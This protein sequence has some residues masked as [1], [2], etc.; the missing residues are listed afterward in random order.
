[1]AISGNR[2]FALAVLAVGSSLAGDDWP[3]WRGPHRDGALASFIAP[4][5]W[6]ETLKRK[7]TVT[8]GEGHASPVFASGKLFVFTRQ[9]TEEALTCIAPDSGKILWRTAYPAPYKVNPAADSHGAGPKSTPVVYEGKV[10]TLGIGGVLSSF[11]AATGKPG[12]RKNFSGEFRETSPWYGTATSPVVDGGMVIA[13]VGGHDDGALMAFDAATGAVKW[14]WQ[15]DGP[16]Y[17]SPILVELAGKRQVIT[18]T[19]QNIVGVAAATGELLWKIPFTTEFTQNA[20]TPLRYDDM[21]IF[22]GL[23]NGTRAVRVSAKNGKWLTDTVWHNKE[24]SMYMNSPVIAGDRVCGFS[25]RNKGQVFCLDA[26][27]GA[28]IWTGP[29][30]QGDN[31]ALI[32]AGD[33]LFVLKDDGEL[34]LAPAGEKTFAPLRRYTVAQSPTWAHPLIL[35]SGIVIKDATTLARW[36]FE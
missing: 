13:H 10:F 5:F 16:G 33:L 28:T 20:V 8:V 30:R 32:V 15:G 35:P 17:A 21:L 31:A 23:S 25:H 1:M 34:Q 29:P 26:R 3:Q 24:M 6:P 7:W 12:W 11:D 19:Q 9:Q 2:A 36:D 4:K 14:K 27:T 22:S 18:Q